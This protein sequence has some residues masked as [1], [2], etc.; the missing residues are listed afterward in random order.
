MVLAWQRRALVLGGIALLV[1][2]ALWVSASVPR[3]HTRAGMLEVTA[4]DVGQGDSLLVVSPQGKTLLIDAGGPVGG[5]QSEFDFGEN[6]VSPYLWERRISHLDVVVITH[7][8]S[9]HIGG[10]HSVL[11]NFCPR[12]LWVGALP[13]TASIRALLNYAASLGIRVVR[14]VDGDSM[15]FGGMQVSVFS[16]P[17]EWHTSSQPR[18]NDSLV[19]RLQYKDSSALLEGDAEKVVEQR[20]VAQEV[21]ASES[22]TSR[23]ARDVGYPTNLLRSDLLKVGHHG[24]ATS[25]SWEFI[26]AVQPRWA[27]ISVGRGNAFGHPR[28]ETL[29]RLQEEGAATYRT[30]LNGAVSFYL[31]GHTVSPQLACL[32]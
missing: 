20:M 23:K 14:H 12:E 29:Q 22:P 2:T 21:V 5:Q 15:E 7:G 24:S 31:D 8:H 9:D 19:M 32:R 25:S 27:I 3:P 1:G 6:V 30:D 16:P 13:E 10:I 26:H 28:L 18:N 4:I 17:L 11:K